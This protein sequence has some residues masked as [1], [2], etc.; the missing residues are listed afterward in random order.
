M[1][2]Q[3]RW[4]HK[5]VMLKNFPKFSP[6][7]WTLE[8]KAKALRSPVVKKVVSFALGPDG[9]N[10]A[11][12]A[13]QWH[14]EMGI[15]DKATINLCE[16]PE[17]AVTRALAVQEEGTLGVFWT[18]AVFRRLNEIFF[19]NPETFPFFF[20]YDMLLDEMQ[21]AAVSREESRLDRPAL[22]V[23][24]THVSPARLVKDLVGNGGARL[25]DASSNA[26]AARRC[27]AGEIT[28]C[29][30]TESA[31]MLHHLTTLHKFGSPLMVFFG[32]IT[33]TGLNLLTA[34]DGR[35]DVTLPLES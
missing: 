26:E 10:I 28:A 8:A 6:E 11:Q 1:E 9:T 27:A 25:V 34:A 30:T 14:A 17:A 18:C 23:I 13:Q 16:L 29:V 2:M 5:F 24:A 31:R 32:G 22:M 19:D 4:E 21:L 15:K 20:S 7:A 35:A 3:Q 33:K 12:A